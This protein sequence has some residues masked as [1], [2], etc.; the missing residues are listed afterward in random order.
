M[1]SS[2]SCF[3]DKSKVYTSL[4]AY[5]VLFFDAILTTANDPLQKLIQGF[6]KHLTYS[7]SL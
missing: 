6:L 1:E 7:P 5:L 2:S 3:G 4:M